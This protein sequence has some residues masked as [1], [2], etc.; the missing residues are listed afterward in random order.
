MKY[1]T[2]VAACQAFFS[3]EPYGRK[4]SIPEFKDLTTQDKLDLS[5]MLNAAG[6]EHPDYEPKTVAA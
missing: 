1:P 2:F 6:Y 4:V 3:E 5:A